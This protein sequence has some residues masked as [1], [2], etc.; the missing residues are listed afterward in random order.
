MQ[1]NKGVFMRKLYVILLLSVLVLPIYA[2]LILKGHHP[3]EPS[4]YTYNQRFNFN[5][6]LGSLEQMKAALKSFTQLTNEIKKSPRR[7]YATE[8]KYKNRYVLIFK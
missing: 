5:N 3:D 8:W 1:I 2:E 6:A 7:S 4:E